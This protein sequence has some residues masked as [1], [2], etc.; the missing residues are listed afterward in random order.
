MSETFQ[1]VLYSFALGLGA[2][3]VMDLWAAMQRRFLD[4]PSLSYCMVGRWLGHIPNGRFVHPKIS[5]ARKVQGECVVGWTA[6]YAIGV[7]FAG[8]LLAIWGSDWVLAPTFGPAIIVGIGTV[9]APFLILQP[10]MGAGIAASRTPNPNIARLRSVM[11]HGAFGIGL[12]VSGIIIAAIAPHLS[13][14]A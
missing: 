7:A 9:L 10:G 13:I 11:A 8:L 4:I 1:F 3:A 12:Y 2:T 5:D 6:H 14:G